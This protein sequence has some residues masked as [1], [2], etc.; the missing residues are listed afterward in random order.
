MA[1]QKSKL[2]IVRTT[3]G[4]EAQ[5]MDR[6]I[7][8]LNRDPNPDIYAIMKPHEIRGYIFVEATSRDTVAQTVYGVTY[9]KGVIE[10]TTRMKQLEHLFAPVAEI[11]NIKK[12]DVVEVASGPFKGEKA[13]VKRINKLKEEVVIELLEAAVPIPLT[14]KLDSVRVIR[15]EEKE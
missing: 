1:K 13:R 5:V 15:R 12:D 2:Y 9:A 8:K 10:G 14:V 4:R 7:A 3:T 6:L 11:I